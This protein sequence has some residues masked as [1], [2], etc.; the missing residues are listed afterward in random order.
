MTALTYKPYCATAVVAFAVFT[1][2]GPCGGGAA[3]ANA[4]PNAKTKH[5]R[6]VIMSNLL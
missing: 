4:L 2:T 3:N 6:R 1:A 5:T